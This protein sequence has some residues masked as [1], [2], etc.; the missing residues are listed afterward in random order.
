[1]E[2]KS[3]DGVSGG[4]DIDLDVDTKDI[5]EAPKSDFHCVE[6]PQ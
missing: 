6:K 5:P 4:L 3:G 2:S 1:M